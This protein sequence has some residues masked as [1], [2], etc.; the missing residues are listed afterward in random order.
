MQT[1]PQN[2]NFLGLDASCSN[3]ATA[4][5]LILPIP[6]EGTTTYMK[7]TANGPQAIL[8]TSQQIEFY[9][10][11]FGSEPCMAGIAT[12]PP[13][14]FDE[15]SAVWRNGLSHETALEK[16]GA[17]AAEAM[18]TGKFFIA[19]GGEHS[20]TIP[21]VQQASKRF[22]G[23][24]VLQLDAHSDLRDSYEGSPTNHAC[25]MARINECCPFVGVGL[26]SGIINE[27]KT[28]RPDA[29]LI[30]AREM[31]HDKSW[32]EQVLERL[33]PT[34][35][36]TVDLDY[37]DPSVMPAVG[38]P[39]PGGFYWYDTLEF[40]RKLFAQKNVIG[41]DVVE[42][43]PIR[44]LIHPDFF[45]ARLVYKLFAYKISLTK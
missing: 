17:A 28:I 22:P 9:D 42:L 44:G 35:Y 43:S 23:L 31:V 16:I 11:E 38:T 32:H 8:A 41:C 6:Y 13:L 2:E 27:E 36:L 30:Y 26:R 19:L 7:G 4:R 20:I 39:E 40:L 10:D 24:S 34:V 21:I 14:T 25:V 18:Q 5:G 3:F 12:L 1:L 15:T 45:A 37:F 33:S 29:H